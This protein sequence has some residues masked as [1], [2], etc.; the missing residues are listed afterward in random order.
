MSVSFNVLDDGW[1]PVILR[2]GSSLQLGIRET[3]RRASEIQRI[4][5]VSPLEEYSIYRFLSVFLMDALR[6]EKQSSIRKLLKQGAFD[7]NQLEQYIQTCEEEGVSFDLFDPDRPFMQ[8]KYVAEWD[9]DPKPVAS[10]DCT[11]PTGNNHTHFD[12]RKTE[13]NVVTF[14]KAAR[15]LLTIQQFCFAV[16]AQ[17]YP[18]GVNGSPPYFSIV[19]GGNLFE[20]LVFTLQPIRSIG[21]EFDSPCALWRS[22]EPV[23]C[24]K[25]VGETS[26]I[27]GMYFPARRVMLIPPENGN[28]VSKVYLSQGEN[29]VNKKSWKDP[30]VTYRTLDTGIAP[31]RPKREKPVWRSM[32]E[33]ADIVGKHASSVL[34]QYND[35]TGAEYAD[36]TLY[37]VETDEGSYLAL[38]RQNIRFP[39]AITNSVAAIE[40]IKQS[41][42]TAERLAG[43]LQ[44]TLTETGK[45]KILSKA[46]GKNAVNDFYQSCETAFWELC[47][48]VSEETDWN[49][50]YLEWCDRIAG[51]ALEA[52]RNATMN[53]RLRGR[54]LGRVAE[55]QR[56]LVVEIRKIKEEAN[57]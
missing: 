26:W 4:S 55:Q 49:A 44:E 32:Y 37:G 27:R 11:L 54:D 2:D 6:P 18:T 52:H 41:V 21:I 36:I 47:E 10:L 51:F 39:A 57:P 13:S 8:S 1:I 9:K 5:C 33:I 38:F 50:A 46:V 20:T 56:W 22:S 42:T 12:H 29:F 16:G 40:L 35:L 45:K 34:N 30:F 14:D 19:N 28:K 24:K 48:T 25:K 31:L 7:M 23:V 15:L 53:L 3:L 17:E 43:K